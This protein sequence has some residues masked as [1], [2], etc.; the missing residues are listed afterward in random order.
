[1]IASLEMMVLAMLPGRGAG[2]ADEGLGRPTLTLLV[3]KHRRAPDG[4]AAVAHW[5]ITPR[6]IFSFCSIDCCVVDNVAAMRNP[7]HATLNA[8][9][10]FMGNC[11]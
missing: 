7:K 6:G 2:D 8:R 5:A 4:A 10:L 3:L 11:S 9:P 1:M